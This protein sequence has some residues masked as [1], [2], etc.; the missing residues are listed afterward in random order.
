M[1]RGEDE[2]VSLSIEERVRAH[3]RAEAEMY[4]ED[5]ADWDDYARTMADTTQGRA[6]ALGIAW[7]DVGA[8][9]RQAWP[10]RQLDTLLAWMT[11]RRA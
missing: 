7:R 1:G 6:M 8:D 2:R 10:G 5:P 9:L 11:R 3:Y 4:V